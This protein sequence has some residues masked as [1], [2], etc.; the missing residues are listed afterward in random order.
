[1]RRLRKS[2]ESGCM[3]KVRVFLVCL[4]CLLVSTNVGW[5]VSKFF[6][7]DGTIQEG[8]I[9]SYVGVYDD[10]TVD[11]TGGEV[12]W[13]LTAYDTS[14]VNIS[15]GFVQALG[16]DSTKINISGTMEGDTFRIIRSSSVNM[17]GGTFDIMEVGTLGGA[18]LYN[19]VISDYLLAVSTVDIYG[20]GFQY[21]PLAGDYRGG[22]LTG[23]WMDD[24]PFSI[25]LY[26][27]YN[28]PYGGTI[29]TWSH[30]S[31]HE[32]PEPCTLALLAFGAIIRLRMGKKQW[33][34]VRQ[35]RHKSEYFVKI[36][37]CFMV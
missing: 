23:F 17:S 3:P 26:A 10:A 29:D 36:G 25:D 22:Q 7:E 28:P 34:S 2:G 6:Y 35:R 18:Y 5:S 31:L 21:N 33:G 1:M 24:T 32:I 13:G 19:G 37:G 9:Y 27:V 11:M 4:A 30:I 12:T 8:E 14:T 16:G 20:Y 15:G